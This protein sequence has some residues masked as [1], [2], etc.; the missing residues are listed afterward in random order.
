M[1]AYLLTVL[2]QVSIIKNIYAS[3]LQDVK[4]QKSVIHTFQML[5][6]GLLWHKRTLLVQFRKLKALS[7]ALNRWNNRKVTQTSSTNNLKLF[8]ESFLKIQ[9]RWNFQE[10]LLSSLG[11]GFLRSC[12]K[13]CNFEKNHLSFHRNTLK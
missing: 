11:N 10:R 8:E 7:T 5:G 4:K 6:S 2:K 13:P 12:R 9:C 3:H 1:C